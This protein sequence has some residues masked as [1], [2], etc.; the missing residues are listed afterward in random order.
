MRAPQWPSPRSRAAASWSFCVQ[1]LPALG[2]VV[3]I[4]RGHHP[5]YELLR[6]ELVHATTEKL[7]AH[8]GAAAG[9]HDEIQRIADLLGD[10]GRY[11]WVLAVHQLVHAGEAVAQDDDGAVGIVV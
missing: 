9:A 4:A 1:G 8:V 3:E 11:A 2:V 10:M 5:D 6:L 7:L